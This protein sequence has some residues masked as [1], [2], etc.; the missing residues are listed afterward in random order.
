MQI[1]FSEYEFFNLCCKILNNVFDSSFEY[2]V[3]GL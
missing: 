3:N 1:L 2:I